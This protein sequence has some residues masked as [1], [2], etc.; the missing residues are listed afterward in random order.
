MAVGG[1]AM[2]ANL[3]AYIESA[4]IEYMAR[5]Y[6]WVTDRFLITLQKSP[7]CKRMDCGNRRPTEMDNIPPHKKPYVAVVD[8]KGRWLLLTNAFSDPADGLVGLR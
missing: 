2:S 6:E 8:T 4:F 1:Q 5:P 3:D 7:L